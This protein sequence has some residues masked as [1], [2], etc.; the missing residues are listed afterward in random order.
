VLQTNKNPTLYAHCKHCMCLSIPALKEDNGYTCYKCSQS[1]LQHPLIRQLGKCSLL[2]TDVFKV[3]SKHIKKARKGESIFTVPVS[4]TTVQIF[5]ENNHDIN[6]GFHVLKDTLNV[7]TK[8]KKP[9]LILFDSRFPGLFIHKK[10]VPS[11]P[12]IA[13]DLLNRMLDEEPK[14]YSESVQMFLQELLATR[15]NKCDNGETLVPGQ[16]TK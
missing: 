16:S 14:E 11:T 13:E 10:Y 9:E 2:Y 7:L 12:E 4:V 1:R 6:I 3:L 8:V 5:I 15:P